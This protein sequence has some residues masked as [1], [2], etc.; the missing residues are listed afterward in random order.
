MKEG[1]ILIKAEQIKFQNTLNFETFK[2]E[3]LS[4]SAAK[5]EPEL[6]SPSDPPVSKQLGLLKKKVFILEHFG[7]TDKAYS[8]TPKF[9]LL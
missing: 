7:S 2:R 8:N 4:C 6:P 9:E 3:F 1:F 5:T